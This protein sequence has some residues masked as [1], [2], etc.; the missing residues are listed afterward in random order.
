MALVREEYWLKLAGRK[1]SRERRRAEKLWRVGKSEEVG[2]KARK[3]LIARKN[4]LQGWEGAELMPVVKWC[5]SGANDLRFA[6]R[7]FHMR[8]QELRNDRSA[9]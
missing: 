6:G 4:A 7:E 8:G 3:K 5:V 9:T 1:R 2:F